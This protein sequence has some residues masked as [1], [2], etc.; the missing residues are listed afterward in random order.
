MAW[1][2]TVL[3]GQAAAQYIP[4]PRLTGP[5]IRPAYSPYLN[6]TRAGN[7]ATNYYGLVR[8]EVE[9]RAAYLNLQQQVGQLRRPPASQTAAFDEEPA[10][11]YPVRFLD[12]GAYFRGPPIGAPQTRVAQQRYRGAQTNII[13]QPPRNR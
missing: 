1:L 10:T 2:M 6:L 12:Y 3:S 7:R 13:P 9:A 5:G 4:P 11:G 8:P